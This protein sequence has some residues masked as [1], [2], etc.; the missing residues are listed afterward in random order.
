MSILHG[1]L[2]PQKILLVLL[3][4]AMGVFCLFAALLITL[5]AV[6]S[7]SEQNQTFSVPLRWFEQIIETSDCRP[8]GEDPDCSQAMLEAVSDG[9]D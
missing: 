1:S 2:S 9:A 5:H 3:V 4:S 7:G 8:S 6:E